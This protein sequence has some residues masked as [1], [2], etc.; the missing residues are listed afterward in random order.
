MRASKKLTAVE[1]FIFRML[2]LELWNKHSIP[3]KEFAYEIGVTRATLYIWR[4]GIFSG[5]GYP[6]YKHYRKLLTYA[7]RVLGESTVTRILH[8]SKRDEEDR[9]RTLGET[10]GLCRT[11]IGGSSPAQTYRKGHRACWRQEVSR[12]GFGDSIRSTTHPFESNPEIC[13]QEK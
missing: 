10:M 8:L 4:H 5:T 2:L 9:G 13:T 7:L 3:V 12:K 1:V 6:R 11:R